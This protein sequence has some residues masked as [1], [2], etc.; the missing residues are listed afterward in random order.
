[1]ALGLTVSTKRS[2]IYQARIRVGF[3]NGNNFIGSSLSNW[4]ASRNLMAVAHQ[5]VGFTQRA[6]AKAR[7]TWVP[8]HRPCGNTLPQLV[9]MLQ[10]L[11]WRVG[12]DFGVQVV[13]A[14]DPQGPLPGVLQST[15]SPAAA[16]SSLRAEMGWSAV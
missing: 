16:R 9:D 12:P 6:V 13:S 8:P 4:S 14:S 15:S 1:M 5:L 3:G 11:H 10:Q 7:P 2:L